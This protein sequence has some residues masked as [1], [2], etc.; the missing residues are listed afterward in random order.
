MLFNPGSDL[1]GLLQTFAPL[2]S[3]RVWPY[4]QALLLGSILAP[5]KR[6][7]SAILRVLG[8]GDLVHFQNYHR[9]FNR[10]QWSHW[11]AEVQGVADL[12]VGLAL[13]RRQHDPQAQSAAL[14]RA[15]RGGLGLES[16][17]DFRI[18]NDGMGGSRHA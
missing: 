8:L 17:S 16:N 1:V 9:V 6:T 15:G 3:L 14:G 10:A 13:V 11:L 2:F 12:L 5:G 7:V 4:A 18:Q